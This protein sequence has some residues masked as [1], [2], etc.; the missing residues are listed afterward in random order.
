MAVA[1]EL[2]EAMLALISHYFNDDAYTEKEA[3]KQLL[4]IAASV[5]FTNLDK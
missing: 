3:I 4:K 5:G 2:Q 1:P